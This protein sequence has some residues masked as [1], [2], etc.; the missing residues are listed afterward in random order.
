MPIAQGKVPVGHPVDA[1]GAATCK[2]V[3]MVGVAGRGGP[4]RIFWEDGEEFDLITDK[5]LL[6]VL[7]EPLE[8]VVA[9]TPYKLGARE[10]LYVEVRHGKIIDFNGR[11]RR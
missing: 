8:L 11:D 6:I 3:D 9:G 1:A 10:N 5:S 2:W 4:N 7:L